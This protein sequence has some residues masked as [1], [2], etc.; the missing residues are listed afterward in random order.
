MY[1]LIKNRMN[2]TALNPSPKVAIADFRPKHSAI[3]RAIK[4]AIEKLDFYF[5][6]NHSKNINK[7]E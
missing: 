1:S 5:K 3:K 4:K 6:N 2:N 7:G